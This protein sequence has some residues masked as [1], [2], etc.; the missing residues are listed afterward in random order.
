[1]I[2]KQRDVLMQPWRAT[3]RQLIVFLGLSISAILLTVLGVTTFLVNRIHMADLRRVATLHRVEYENKMASLGSLGAG[4][5][6]E[7]NNPL[8]IINEKAG[9]I[10]DMFTY[11]D[12]Y[13]DDPKLLAIVDSILRSVNRCSSI[14]RR[15][16]GFARNTEAEIGP[17][18]L[19]D[20]V[21][22]VLGF[23]GKEAE[24]RSVDVEVDV[25]EDIPQII[26]N[27]GT[28]QQVLLNLV[29]NAF[30]AVEDG[31]RIEVSARPKGASHVVIEVSDNGCGISEADLTRVF[32]PFFTTKGNR[33][34]T[35]LGLSITY[36]LVHEM[37][38]SLTVESQVGQGTTF[39]IALPMSQSS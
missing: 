27:P 8:A 22:Q 10:K 17:V 19:L 37:G 2:V 29:N 5:A 7:I 12:R 28:L 3:R 13:S 36:S 30:A 34:G 15:L 1:M 38:G 26:S 33:G 9:L 4:V 23:M 11:T 18:N 25:A 32:E 39:T 24:H 31:G 21:G 6:H 14:T 16:L 20:A 35:G